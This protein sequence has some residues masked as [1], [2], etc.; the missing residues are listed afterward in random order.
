MPSMPSQDFLNLG[1]PSSL[2]SCRL[3]PAGRTW[4]T[5]MLFSPELPSRSV[6]SSGVMATVPPRTKDGGDRVMTGCFWVLVKD[7]KVAAL[8]AAALFGLVGLR[9][10]ASWADAVPQRPCPPVSD[11]NQ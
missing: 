5:V 8:Q 1:R 2:V 11:R 7:R 6:A 10:A 3:V 4:R 9:R